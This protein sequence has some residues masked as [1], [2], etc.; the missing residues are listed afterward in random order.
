MVAVMPDPD[1]EHLRMYYLLRIKGSHEDNILCM[2]LSK[3]GYTWEKPDLGDGTNIVM[4]ASGNKMEWGMYHPQIVI[5]DEADENP[6]HRWKMLYWGRHNAE[7]PPGFHIATSADGI[8]WNVENNRPIIT[9]GND[10]GSMTALNPRAAE[11]ARTGSVLLYQQTWKYNPALPTERDNLDHFHRVISIWTA[12]PFPGNWIGPVQVLE[13]DAKDDYD[14]QFYWFV[15][16][17]HGEGYYGLMNIHHTADQTMDVQLMSSPNGWSWNRELA[18]EPLVPLG[19][20]GSFDS[21]MVHVSSAPVEWQGK[22]L[23]YYNGR[24]T[25][26][27]GKARHPEDELPSPAKGVGVVVLDPKVFR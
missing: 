19:P 11:G 4:R 9:N 5:H 17:A 3:D 12:E 26:H 8:N 13:P 18:R 2:A 7:L 22:L 25:L 21:G 10:A 23:L 1:G 20:R 15:P 14:E 24:A 16:F 6:D 27:D